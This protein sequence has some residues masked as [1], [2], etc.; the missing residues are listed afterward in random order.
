[1]AT[2]T[3]SAVQTV[4]PYKVKVTS[5]NT[6]QLSGTAQVDLLLSPATSVFAG[7]AVN[8]GIQV[9]GQAIS[10]DPVKVSFDCSTV[11]DSNGHV[12]SPSDL[13]IS[14][15]SNP[16]VLTLAQAK[17]SATIIIE[18]T[19]AATSLAVGSRHANWFYALLLP[20]FLLAGFRSAPAKHTCIQGYL[21]IAVAV[22]LPL[23]ISCGG[24][25]TPPKTTQ[26][27]TPAGSYQVTVVDKLVGCQIDPCP[28]TSGF[29]QTTLIV[30]LVVSPT[31]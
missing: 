14:C 15:S 25:F 17:N 9:S 7:Q 30:P 6:V 26:I 20:T 12:S 8:V 22:M 2:K 21:V 13:N 18:T 23:T 16:S 31:Q 4:T 5:T 29:V 27:S 1:V 3:Y 11:I 28:T 10:N 19:G 24:G